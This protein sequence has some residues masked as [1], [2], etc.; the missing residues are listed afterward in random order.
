MTTTHQGTAS[1]LSLAEDLRT[2]APNV[3]SAFSLSIGAGLM[4]RAAEVIERMAPLDPDIEVVQ[5]SE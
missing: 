2:F 1:L 5:G 3:R 4:E